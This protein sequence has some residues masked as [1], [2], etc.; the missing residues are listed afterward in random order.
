MKNWLKGPDEVMPADGYVSDMI[1]KP[2]KLRFQINDECKY[3]PISLYTMLMQTTLFKPHHI[4]HVILHE[5]SKLIETITYEEYLNKCITA[6]KSLIKMGVDVTTC[7]SIFTS[8]S[9]KCFIIEL[10]TVFAGGVFSGYSTKSSLEANEYMLS[11]TQSNIVFVEDANYLEKLLNIKLI[12]FKWIVQIFG[13]INEKYKNHEYIINWNCFIK[14]GIGVESSVFESHIKSISP[15]KCAILC[16]T[17][18]TTD[19]QPKICMLSHD[20]LTYSTRRLCDDLN[21]KPYKERFLSF[22]PLYHIS[23]QYLDLAL[24]ICCGATVYFFPSNSDELIFKYSKYVQPTFFCGVPKI[25]HSL[26]S[27]IIKDYSKLKSNLNDNDKL[28]FVKH[29][30]GLAKCKNFLT[31][32]EIIDKDTLNYF[33]NI[34]LPLLQFYCSTEVTYNSI[35]KYPEDDIACC[36]RVRPPVSCKLNQQGEL[37]VYG[38]NVFMGYLGNDKLNSKTF[39]SHAWFHTGDLADIDNQ[40]QLFIKGR[41]SDTICT[42]LTTKIQPKWLEDSIKEE[43]CDCISNCVLVSNNHDYLIALLTL[44]CKKDEINGEPIDELDSNVVKLINEFNCDTKKPSEIAKLDKN[45]PFMQWIS[46]KIKKANKKAELYS[47]PD[48]E[49]AQVKD[50]IILDREL[51]TTAGELNML[52]KVR[53]KNVVENFKENIYRLFN[54]INIK[55]Q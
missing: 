13:D 9:S 40:G 27:M 21:L 38:R 44:Q 29:K 52:M 15:N 51:T 30:Y 37:I 14:M 23:G 34:G 48:T 36:G 50:F 25:W 5:D 45:H 16:H 33:L 43:L 49:H 22:F 7:V 4:A 28:A 39:N 1:D 26:R 18:G 41:I 55:E 42:S 2:V 17:S 47:C 31:G 53:R 8:N 20:N 19:L 11:L 3:P 6:A 10:A 35:S 32:G 54:E 12:E 46:V 24:A